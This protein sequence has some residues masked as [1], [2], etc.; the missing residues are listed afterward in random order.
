MNKII[1]IRCR[2]DLYCIIKSL[3]YLEAEGL[4]SGILLDTQDFT[5]HTGVRI[6]S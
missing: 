4:L 5:L 3:P 6:D 1:V 2:F